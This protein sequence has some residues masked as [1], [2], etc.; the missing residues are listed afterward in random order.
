LEVWSNFTKLQW[1]SIWSDGTNI[2]IYIYI[3]WG[4]KKEVAGAR[5]RGSILVGRVG[6]FNHGQT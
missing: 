6:L 2:Y 3:E 1:G 4:E 5:R